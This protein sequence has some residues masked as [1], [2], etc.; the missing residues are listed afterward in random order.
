MKIKIQRIIFP[1]LLLIFIFSF[2]LTSAPSARADEYNAGRF[3]V[4]VQVY[5]DLVE[6]TYKIRPDACHI[7]VFNVDDGYSIMYSGVGYNHLNIPFQP[8]VNYRISLCPLGYR[9]RT[10]GLLASTIPST[11]MMSTGFG[12]TYDEYE[13]TAWQKIIK[14]SGEM[15]CYS[16]DS[17][18]AVESVMLNINNQNGKGNPANTHH[19]TK[20][21][22]K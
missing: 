5:G 14:P 20:T 8:G 1:C 7:Y 19:P 6:V 10:N 2:V 13:E 21:Q 4:D 15:L 17:A 22:R 3:I 11:F 12:Y 16:R 18:T 9:G